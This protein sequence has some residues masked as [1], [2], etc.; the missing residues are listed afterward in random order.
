MRLESLVHEQ[1]MQQAKAVRR[2]LPWGNQGPSVRAVLV[3][4]PARV[5]QWMI[6]DSEGN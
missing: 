4:T 3:D 5:W 1:G 2:L 6:N